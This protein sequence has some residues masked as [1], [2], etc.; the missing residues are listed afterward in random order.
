[1]MDLA[2]GDW[3]DDILAR[4]AIERARLARPAPIAGG[5]V[6]RL[7]RNW[8]RNSASKAKCCW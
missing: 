7:R 2:T 5:V 6:G 4:C 3:D 1:M 8:R